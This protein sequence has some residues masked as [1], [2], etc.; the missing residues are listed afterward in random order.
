MGGHWTRKVEPG[1][2][3]EDSEK[4]RSVSLNFLFCDVR[5]A[6]TVPAVVLF[7]RFK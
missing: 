1:A 6:R 7:S 2:V 4:S 3:Q 5:S